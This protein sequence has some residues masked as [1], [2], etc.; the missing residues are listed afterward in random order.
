M[1]KRLTAADWVAFALKILARR[2]FE[3]LKADVLARELG[4]SRGSFYWHFP[5]L[6]D[7]H[8]AV[9]S[10]WQRVATD[11]IIADI[12]KH[13]HLE[14]RLE[15]L[16]RHAFGESVRLEVRMRAWGQDNAQAAKA[17]AQIDSRRLDYIV[18]MIVR[19]GVPQD[20]ARAR[21][22]LLYWAYIGAAAAR[23]KL[24]QRQLDLLVTELLR[25][26]LAPKTG[27][28]STA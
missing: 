4:V 27:S 18:A 12:E 22:Q 28:G 23:R 24:T 25:L 6:A 11:A 20:L 5:D 15:A 3:S 16:L 17:V 14:Q 19:Q 2:G 8:A 1:S 21:A 10:E 26:A 7:F 13:S 9:I